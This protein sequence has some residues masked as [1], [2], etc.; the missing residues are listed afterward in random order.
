MDRRSIIIS[1]ISLFFIGSFVSGADRVAPVGLELI[2]LEKVRN[3]PDTCVYNDVMNYSVSK[4]FGDAHGRSTNVHETIHGI[5]SYLRNKAVKETKNYKLNGFYAG[6]GYGIIVEN[7]NLRLR[8]VRDYV[9]NS[10]RG[11]RFKLYFEQQLGDWDDTPTYHMDEWAAYIGGAESAVDDYNNKIIDPEK[12][13]SVSGSLEFSI[14]CT[15]LAMAVKEL[16]KKYWEENLQF[17]YAINYYLIKAEKVFFEGQDK[18]PS[19]KQDLLLQNLRNSTDTEI[20][21]DF[22][23]QEFQGIF[24]D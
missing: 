3:L 1:I 24:I 23:K 8:Q 14:Y 11:Y 17:K 12:S 6:N 15:V 2:K 22:L 20:M 16:D 18:F 9:P 19:K 13:D 21:R 4:P 7:P 5:N 10:V